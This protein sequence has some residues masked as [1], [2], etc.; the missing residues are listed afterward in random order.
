MMLRNI[1]YIDNN[2]ID[3]YISQID[4]Y[5]YE[6]ETIVDSSS[7]DKGASGRIGLGKF[8]S[9]GKIE[10]Q[11]TFSSTKNVKITD[12]SKLDKIIKYLEKNDEVRY[13]E[14][15]TSQLWNNIKRNDFLELL[16]IPRFSKMREMSNMAK[17]INNMINVFQPYVDKE[18]LNNKAKNPYLDLKQIPI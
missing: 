17:S 16:V 15:I 18:I 4:G 2:I 5:T 1:L 7:K 13:Y 8:N 3:D 10:N 9:E 6:E 12:A 14:L 11:E